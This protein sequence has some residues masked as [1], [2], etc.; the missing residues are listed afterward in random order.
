M[1]NFWKPL[2]NHQGGRSLLDTSQIVDFSSSRHRIDP[3]EQG[4]KN[5]SRSY[6]LFDM[7]GWS[8]LV[9]SWAMKISGFFQPCFRGWSKNTVRLK[10][11]K[12]RYTCTAVPY[13]MD[14]RHRLRDIDLYKLKFWSNSTLCQQIL[15][16]YC[17][18]WATMVRN[19]KKNGK[20]IP[21][22]MVGCW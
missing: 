11:V 12:S 9:V 17:P 22:P 14:S 2:P 15:P 6:S 13:W 5:C 16:A 21:S 4:W 18:V 20:K 10:F 1:R 8:F 3:F 19:E 7:F